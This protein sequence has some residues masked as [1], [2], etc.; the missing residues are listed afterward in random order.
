MEVTRQCILYC[1]SIIIICT[2]RIDWDD[3]ELEVNIIDKLQFKTKFFNATIF[4]SSMRMRIVCRRVGDVFTKK[5][6]CQKSDVINCDVIKIDV[7]NIMYM[8]KNVSYNEGLCDHYL[9]SQNG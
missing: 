2:T 1:L 6:V 3:N 4:F 7:F 8:W 9:Q 5:Y